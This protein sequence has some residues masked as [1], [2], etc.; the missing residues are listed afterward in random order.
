MNKIFSLLIFV[1][2]LAS[3]LPA[4]TS[5]DSAELTKLLN[6]F[7]AGA[8]RNDSAIHFSFWADD[9]IYTG[10]SG[11]RIGKA[12]I[13]RDM[14]S[15]PKPGEP[16]TIFSAEDIRIHQYGEA[17]IVAFRLVGTTTSDGKSQV[18]RYFNTGT[19]VKRNGAWQAAGWQATRIPRPEEQAKQEVSEA[20]AAFHQA[21]LASDTTRLGSLI[22]E[23]F[24]WMHPAGEQS[25]RQQLLDDVGSGRLKY[26]KAVTDSV[27]VSVHGDAAIVWGASTTLTF[28]NKGGEWKAVAMHTNRP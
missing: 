8:S 15:A 21:M 20:E 1:V 22:D 18:S 11:R 16:T 26:S 6:E 7:L 25:M 14:R 10:S 23:R 17:A 9:L 5:P 13:M 19:F 2:T 24:I 12:D 4:Q 27:T 28:V 3:A